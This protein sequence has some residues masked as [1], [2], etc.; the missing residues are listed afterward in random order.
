MLPELVD[1]LDE[2]VDPSV[3]GLEGEVAELPGLGDF[4]FVE[5]LEDL[6]EVFRDEDET[7]DSLVDVEELAFD[8]VEQF[9][10]A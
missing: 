10:V 8:L 3:E 2:I 9:I 7:A 4:V 5:A 6:L 1:T